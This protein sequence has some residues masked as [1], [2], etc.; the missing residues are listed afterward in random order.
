M[1]NNPARVKANPLF[2]PLVREGQFSFGRMVQILDHK[3]LDYQGLSCLNRTCLKT[4]LSFAS[5]FFLLFGRVVDN[6]QRSSLSVPFILAVQK[7]ASLFSRVEDKQLCY[8]KM[9]SGAKNHAT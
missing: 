1:E 5:S 4:V 7:R 3:S 6:A 8:I 9:P 2:E